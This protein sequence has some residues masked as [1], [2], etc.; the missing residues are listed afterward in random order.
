MIVTTM[1]LN[2]LCRV[3]FKQSVSELETLAITLE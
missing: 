3:A 1:T 2:V